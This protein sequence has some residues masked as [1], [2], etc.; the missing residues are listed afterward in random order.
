M[1]LSETGVKLP[2]TFAEWVELHGE[3]DYIGFDDA[4]KSD[5]DALDIVVLD[6]ESEEQQ[7][8]QFFPQDVIY[9][10]KNG[11]KTINYDKFLDAFIT[12]N[13]C[14]YCNGMFFTPD[15]AVSGDSIRTDLHYSLKNNGWTARFDAPVDA[16]FKGLRDRCR[17]SA[18]PV[19]EDV[20]PLQNGDLHTGNGTWEFRL[21]E[22][23]QTP[24]RLPVKYCP[25]DA[26]APLFTKW[27]TELFTPED[28]TTVQEI[29][30]Y[31]L[32]PS[33]AAQEAFFLVGEG[34]T[35]K[36]GIGRILKGLLGGAFEEINAQALVTKRFQIATV[37]NK[38]VAYDDDLGSAALTET[39]LLK[40][41]I[42]AD[43]AIPAER[44]YSDPYNFMSYCRIVA[45]ANFMLSSLY[46]DSSGFY[47]RLHPILVKPKDPSRKNIDGFYDMILRSERDQILRWALCGLKR[48]KAH[49]FKVH[50]SER[51]KTYMGVVKSNGTHFED[52][53]DDTMEL[54]EGSS[55]PMAEI[56][57]LYSRWCMDNAV[58]PTSNRRLERWF[59]DN[60]AKYGYKMDNHLLYK[61]RRVRGYRGLGMKRV[62]S[63]A[64]EVTPTWC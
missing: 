32:V 36:S 8:L 18:L 24:Y 56:K 6:C 17:V 51:S 29:F 63:E 23:K 54:S 19:S 26:P 41:L 35:G 57:R 15:G 33:T 13:N 47:R 1:K 42:T 2:E 38:L 27:L 20:I 58:E 16:L 59:A 5:P 21:G 22:K 43:T 10:D 14:V 25:E 9:C 39:G 62:W 3:P 30:G 12:M 44:K 28:I 55:I 53:F 11:K 45:S 40:K 50:W 61:G 7:G 46:D 49:G 34:E 60:A 37:E 4:P 64:L 48:V 52:F 31:C